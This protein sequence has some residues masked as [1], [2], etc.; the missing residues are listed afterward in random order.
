[1]M[2]KLERKLRNKKN[3]LYMRCEQKEKWLLYASGKA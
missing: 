2:N 3:I 1:M